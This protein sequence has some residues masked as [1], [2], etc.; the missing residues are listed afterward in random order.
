[1]QETTYRLAVTGKQAVT[2]LKQ[3]APILQLKTEQAAIAIHL[4][5]HI[6]TARSARGRIAGGD[7][8]N[9]H[10][11][12]ED[13]V[14]YRHGLYLEMRRLNQ[15]DSKEFWGARKASGKSSDIKA[16]YGVAKAKK[17]YASITAADVTAEKS[18]LAKHLQ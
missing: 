17:E 8:L 6:D 2:A 1:M 14:N 7:P 3:L 9:V 4:H 10:R 15:K 18:E 13:I 12:P 5:E 16:T 11:T